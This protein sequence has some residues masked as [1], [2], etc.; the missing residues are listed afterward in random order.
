MARFDFISSDSNG[1]Q[2]L[3]STIWNTLVGELVPA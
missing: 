1:P 3:L 2:S